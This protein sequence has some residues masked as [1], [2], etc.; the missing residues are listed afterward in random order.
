M[1]G[2][3]AL[4]GFVLTGPEWDA[5]DEVARAQLLAMVLRRDGAWDIPALERWERGEEPAEAVPRA[6]EDTAE[7]YAHYELV[8]AAAA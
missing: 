3:I 1:Q 8:L 4:A 2:D 5:L 7:P 6:I